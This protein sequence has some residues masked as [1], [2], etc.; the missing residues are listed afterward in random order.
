[1]LRRW[2]LAIVLFVVV[3]GVE[4]LAAQE[5]QTL[6]LSGHGKDDPVQW[7]FFCSAGQNS[8][9]WTTIGV[10]SNWEL[11]GFGTY[12]YGHDKSKGTEQGRYRYSFELPESWKNK[13]IEIVFEGVMTDTRVRVNGISAGPVHQGGFYRFKYDITRLVKFGTPNLLEVTVSK[14]SSNKTVEA[15][16]RQADYWVF[17]GIYRPV[18]L[19][20]FPKQHIERTAIDARA[21]GTISVDVYLENI[22]TA[23]QMV[24]MVS[25]ANA[26]AGGTL[27]AGVTE[28]QHKVTLKARVRGVKPW[29]AETPNLYTLELR[30]MKNGTTIHKTSER[31]GFRTFEVRPGQG[32]FLNGRK[33]RLKGVCRHCF[34]PDSGR[35]LSRRVSYDDVR[36]VKQMNMNAVRMSHYPPDVHFLDACDELGLY[37]LDELAGWHKP[38]YDTQIGKTLVREMVTRDVSHP[39]ILFWDNGNEGGWNR[40]LDSQFALYDPQ[41]RTVL[42]PSANFNGIDT[43]HYE[44][45]QNTRNKL[46]GSTLFMPTEFLHGLYDGGLGAGL[47]DYWNLM[48]NSPLGAGGFLWALLDEGV[49]R[50]DKNGVIDTDGNHAPDGVLGP[51][52]QKEGSFYTIKEIW[53][54]IYI[55]LEELG[56]D[57]SGRVEVE[58]RYDFTDLRKCRFKWELLTFPKPWEDKDKHT[59]V[60]AGTMPGPDVE[61]DDKG[62][63]KLNLPQDW[64]QANALH[65]TAVNTSGKDVWTWSWEIQ[66]GCARC[67]QY[68]KQETKKGASIAVTENDLSLVVKVDDLSVWF[69]KKNG[70]LAKVEKGGS[71]ISF[72]KG[73]RLIGRESKLTE[74]KHWRQ[75]D[76]V[77]VQATYQGGMDY[78]KWK[79]YPTGWVSLEYQYELEGDFDL[80]GVTFDYPENKMIRMKWVGRGPYRVWKNRTKGGWLDI[81]TNNYKDHTPGVTWDFPEFRGYYRDWHW[82]VFDTQEGKITLLNGTKAI[83]LG[84]YTPKNGPDPAHTRLDLPPAGISLLHGIPAI[85]TKFTRAEKLGPQGHRNHAS[86]KYK[87][88]VCFHF[89]KDE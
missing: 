89:G 32:L 54:P 62:V 3:F 88:T 64:R 59:V 17:G 47:D 29:T 33:I 24:G 16:E 26:G 4:P 56:D 72:G 73:P 12:N 66:K 71:Q 23:D 36:L 53:S 42:H 6:Y 34:W 39:C 57:F 79:I 25:D 55:G 41:G 15:A 85:G 40:A 81:W 84:V 31:F 35:C 46:A 22:T 48:R 61:P 5:T 21:D 51:Y 28:G 82:V 18:Y 45:Y 69:D 80:M 78:A 67:H 44:N 20:A 38:A 76:L 68:V 10:P 7:D 2:T 65:L 1:M 37:V 49:V 13:I 8:G 87:G 77:F 75:G 9:R 70:E 58:N 60:S 19:Q 11:Q 50:T 74:L 14:V 27:S 83:F 63:L 52:R 43:D 86:G 30:L